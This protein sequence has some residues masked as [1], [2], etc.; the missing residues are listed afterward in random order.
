MPVIAI[1]S[2]ITGLVWQV[3]KQPGDLVEVDEPVM[4]VESMKM[5]IP[6]L[7][8]HAGRIVELLAGKDD[9]VKEGETVATLDTAP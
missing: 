9:A 5:E 2:D 3:L 4:I 7:A 8:P 1:T 6:V